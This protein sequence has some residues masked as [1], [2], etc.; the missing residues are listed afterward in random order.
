MTIEAPAYLVLLAGAPLAA[1]LMWSGRRRAAAVMAHLVGAARAPRFARTVL[2]KRAAAGALLAMAVALL[3]LAAA[4]LRWGRER[5][6]VITAGHEVT[7]LLDLSYSMRAADVAPSRLHGAAAILSGVAAEL[8]SARIGLTVFRGETLDLLPP[9]ADR[10]A[11]AVLLTRLT[12]ALPPAPT[13]AQAQEAERARAAERA[14]SVQRARASLP[15]PPPGSD[16][17]RALEQVIARLA[18]RP[19]PRHTVLLLTDGEATMAGRLERVAPRAETRAALAGGSVSADVTVVPVVI[20]TPAGIALL[21]TDG[22][23]VLDADGNPVTTRARAAD[24]A[25]LARAA[26]IEVTDAARIGP[27]IRAAAA[28]AGDGQ[29]SAAANGRGWRPRSR[30]PELLLAGLAAA[31]AAGLVRSI[32]WRGSL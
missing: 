30:T 5:S 15:L 19:Q 28:A 6:A 10:G 12:E 2:G 29:T 27:A 32:R 16:I 13:P 1:A 25:G 24:M 17:T 4:D 9:T 18:K 26:P 8:D 22:R 11:L 7:V 23:A 31:L 20:G 14:V 21:R 3:A